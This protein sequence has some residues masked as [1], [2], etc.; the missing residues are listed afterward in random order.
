MRV[1]YKIGFDGAVTVELEK[2][3]QSIENRV[4]GLS[5]HA[6]ISDMTAATVASGSPPPPCTAGHEC[7]AGAKG[8]HDFVVVVVTAIVAG[9]ATGFVAGKVAAKPKTDGA[10]AGLTEFFRRREWLGIRG[11]SYANGA[12]HEWVGF[13]IAPRLQ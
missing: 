5:M 4:N 12:T 6:Q 10:K 3:L 11:R 1:S 2:V 9:A 7:P 8:G 13:A